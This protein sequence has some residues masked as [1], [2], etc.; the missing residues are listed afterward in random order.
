MSS[1]AERFIRRYIRSMSALELLLHLRSHTAEAWTAARLAQALR[2][3]TVAMAGMLDDFAGAGLLARDSV[4]AWR[5]APGSAEDD[6]ALDEIETMLKSQPFVL[7]ELILA[8]PN[9][10]LKSFSDAF[11]LRKD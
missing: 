11:R 1:Q 7:M 10:S 6:A 2:G 9:E 5:Y 8:A 3:N 4:D